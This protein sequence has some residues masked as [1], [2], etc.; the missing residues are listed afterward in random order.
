MAANKSNSMPR[1]V[2]DNTKPPQPKIIIPVK[3][4][5]DK[6]ASEDSKL[7]AIWDEQISSKNASVAYHKA[8]VLLL[9]WHQDDD[10]L[11]VEQEVVY[12][13]RYYS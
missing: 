4:Y 7:K 13:Q 6:E 2:L 9:S 8:H 10:D 11:N 12:F 3:D 1:N 5:Q